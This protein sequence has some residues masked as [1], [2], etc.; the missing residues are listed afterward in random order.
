MLQLLD[1][2]T[3]LQSADLVITGEGC[4]D[5]QTAHGKLCKVVSDHARKAGVPVILLSGALGER[6]EELEDF[7]DGILS[8]SSKP[9]SLEE[10]LNDTPENLRRMG[11]TI[12]NLLLFSKTLS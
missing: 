7:F 5:F 12:L 9:C 4:S 2:D 10:A 6:S 1:F 11:R 3:A 8:L